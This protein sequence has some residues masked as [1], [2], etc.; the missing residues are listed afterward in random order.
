MKIE[1]VDF[2]AGAQQAQGIAV[3]IDVFRA[4]TTACCCYDRGAKNIIAVDDSERALDY[5]NQ[6]HNCV[7]LGE[8]FGQRLPGFDFGNSPS[9]ILA[10]DLRGKTIVHTT[11]AGTQGLVNAVNADQ[12]LTGAFVNA[13]ATAEFILKQQP[14]LV[15][16]V[17]MGLNANEQSDEDCMYAD[18]LQTL[19]SGKPVDE[20]MLAGEL[21]KSPYAARFFDDAQPWSPEADFECCVDFNRYD[22]V[23]EAHKLNANACQLKVHLNR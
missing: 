18:Y 22:F 10:E 20:L 5:R 14:K 3:I 2:V 19:L 16:L 6:Y 17:R 9:E 8:R 12:V 7:L 1:I 21:K 11:H 4:F 23:L 13:R 15:T